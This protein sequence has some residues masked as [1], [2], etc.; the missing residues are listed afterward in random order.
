MSTTQDPKNTINYLLGDPTQS[1]AL[2]KE[3]L[4]PQQLTLPVSMGHNP[5]AST[6]GL[7][8][9][10]K[11]Q[12]RKERREKRAREKRAK[13]E[14]GLE[15]LLEKGLEESKKRKKE[16]N[17]RRRKARKEKAKKKKQEAIAGEKQ[18]EVRQNLH[19]LADQIRNLQLSGDSTP[20]NIPRPGERGGPSFLPLLLPQ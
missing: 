19:T 1:Q 8:R 12:R 10:A 14:G 13:R 5:T 18:E 15:E 9:S 4:N 11:Q 17:A 2:I 6:E 16:R 20:I 3:V 7:P